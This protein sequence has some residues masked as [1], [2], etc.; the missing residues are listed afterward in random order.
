MK[1]PYMVKHEGKYYPPNTEI[2]ENK[3]PDKEP[4][5]E[6]NKEQKEPNRLRTKNRA[7]KRKSK[8]MNSLERLRIRLN[9]EEVDEDVLIDL[10]GS[11]KNIILTYRYPCGNFRL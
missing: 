8:P 7:A 10:L 2:P 9:G 11:A 5:K 6:P 1:Y 4:Q 3:E